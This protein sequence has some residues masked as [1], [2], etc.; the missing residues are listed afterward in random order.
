MKHRHCLLHIL[1]ARLI[2]YSLLSISLHP[3]R[4][5]FTEQV[6]CTDRLKGLDQSVN[7]HLFRFL[8]V[9]VVLNCF[10]F[11]ESQ[12]LAETKSDS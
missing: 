1:A 5:L 2:G 3:Y 9:T 10:S 12:I 7:Y 4:R 11:D 6:T 8:L